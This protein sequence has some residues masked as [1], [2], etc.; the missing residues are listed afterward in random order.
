ML[1]CHANRSTYLPILLKGN[2]GVK[3]IFEFIKEKLTVGLNGPIGPFNPM[4]VKLLFFL[5]IVIFDNLYLKSMKEM[6]DWCV[7]VC[8]CVYIYMYIYVCVCVYVGGRERDKAK[9]REI[10]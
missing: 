1:I 8:L 2:F 3:I 5:L 6:F 10:E 4:L 9:E 7:Y